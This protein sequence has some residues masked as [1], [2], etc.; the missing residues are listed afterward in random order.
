LKNFQMYKLMIFL[1]VSLKTMSCMSS[2]K[3]M[4]FSCGTTKHLL[5]TILIFSW[6]FLTHLVGKCSL[7]CH[8]HLYIRGDIYK[9]R[10]DPY[11][12]SSVIYPC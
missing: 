9:S 6:F 3:F 8:F 4:C 7:L 11:Y 10:L 2:H 12:I 1:F 5:S